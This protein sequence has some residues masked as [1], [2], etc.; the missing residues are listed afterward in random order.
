MFWT[1]TGGKALLNAVVTAMAYAGPTLARVTPMRRAV[2][3]AAERELAKVL[4]RERARIERP[5][6][7]YEDR[8]TMQKEF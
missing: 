5:P 3:G 7:V 8:A 6:G 1:T 2:I 4:E